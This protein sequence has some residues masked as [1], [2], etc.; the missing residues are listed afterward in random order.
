MESDSI[1]LRRYFSIFW[2]YLWLIALTTLLAGGAAYYVS[3]GMTPVYRAT[4]VLKID[5]AKNPEG[6]DI[7]SM[8]T[9]G[10]RLGK[11][12]VVQIQSRTVA[13]RVA[14]SL[15]MEVSPQELDKLAD[16]ISAQQVRDTQLIEISVEDPNP[17]VA[18]GLANRVAEVFSEQVGGEQRARFDNYQRNLDEQIAGL[19]ARIAEVQKLLAGL[20]DS[21]GGDA[22]SVPAYNRLEMT[23]LQTELTSLQTRYT[24][25]L[26]S[27]EEFR[28]AAARYSDNVTLLAPAELPTSPV[29]PSKMKNT[30]LGMVVGAMVGVGA[31]FLRE[32][33]DDTIKTADDVSQALGLVTLG[34][35]F[36]IGAGRTLKD[37][38][39]T[40]VDGR[41]PVAESYRILRTN[42]AFCGVGNP[43]GAIVVTSAGLGEGKTTTAANLAVVM[44]QMGKRVILVDTDLRRP[45]LAKMFEM[46]GTDG[47]STLLAGQGPVGDADLIPS[48]VPNL[49]LIPS[50]P[51]PPNPAEL[52]GSP[53]M[54][55][56]I[57]SLREQAD[58]VIFDAP[59]ALAVTD[60]SVIASQVDGALLVIDAGET[61]REVVQR[62]AEMLQKGG[63]KLLGA[64]LNK[65]QP[66][67]RGGYYYQYY[68]KYYGS[69][70]KRHK[71]R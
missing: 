26:S 55:E 56:V 32:Y 68:Y 69:E 54:A 52:L 21:L 27:A 17:A 3:A 39:V 50:G 35:I 53:R 46:N 16:K 6:S 47:M 11:T 23:R 34:N 2:K 51:I 67:K 44:A 40:S 18:Q 33:L 31:A 9:A 62:A 65:L 57:Q 8:L 48:E 4:A 71:K 60:S 14:E 15:G 42:L 49:R 22:S 29:S 45:M 5:L 63:V 43:G 19:E 28:L 30:L 36:R 13:A 61:R 25:L 58:V 64:V 12:Y 7:V 41:S 66:G 24:I 20:G 37:S 38:L 10:E 59:P 1:E 70:K